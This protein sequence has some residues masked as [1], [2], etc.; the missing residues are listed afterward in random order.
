MPYWCQAAPLHRNVAFTPHHHPPFRPPAERQTTSP[1]RLYSDHHD[2]THSVFFT[3][4]PTVA[5]PVPGEWLVSTRAFGA[6]CPFTKTRFACN[7][8]QIQDQLGAEIETAIA[9]NLIQVQR[10]PYPQSRRVFACNLVQVQRSSN[11]LAGPAC[12]PEAGAPDAVIMCPKVSTLQST[13]W[14]R[15]LDGSVPCSKCQLRTQNW[16]FRG[17]FT[18]SQS[19]QPPHKSQG[20]K[21][22][23]PA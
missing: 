20:S 17:A 19:A 5:S 14:L 4:K 1:Y 16:G 23:V 6:D 3:P 8:V 9:R 10:P 11:R 21:P 7:L 22:P 12:L 18:P 15:R 13:R 2:P